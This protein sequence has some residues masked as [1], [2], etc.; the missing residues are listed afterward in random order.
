[1]KLQ[2]MLIVLSVYVIKCVCS[3]Y[4]HDSCN[5]AAMLFTH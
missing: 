3:N 1:M 5:V 2:N 4:Y